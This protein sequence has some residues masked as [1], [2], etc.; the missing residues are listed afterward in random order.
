VKKIILSL[1]SI[2]IFA[3]NSSYC[4]TDQNIRPAFTL[5][6]FVDDST[7]YQA[8]MGATKYVPKDGV[9]QIFP[10]EKLFIE[11]EIRNDSLVNLK[12]VTEITH[13]EKTLTIAFI[14][15][16][17]D[18]VHEQMVL[19]INNPFSKKLT[20][21]AHIDL[22][23]QK[24]WVETDVVPLF[25]SVLGNETWQDLITTIALSDFCLKK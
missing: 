21:R 24:K 6:L 4:Q 5:K 2:L 17:K 1:L 3:C 22:M 23:K 11:A 16:H 12:T 25:P 8:P 15:E 18:K 19:H 13:K 20:Y 7:F 9:V 14:Q 10:G